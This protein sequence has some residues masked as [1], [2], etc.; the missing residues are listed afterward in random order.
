[1]W[2]SCPYNLL[3]TPSAPKRS[4]IINR[5][6]STYGN[7][8]GSDGSVD[9]LTGNSASAYSLHH[10]GIEYSGG[11]RAPPDNNINSYKSELEGVK[12][13]Q[14]AANE[15]E[16][17]KLTHT[18]D[19]QSAVDAI[20]HTFHTPAQMLSPEADIILAI[21]HQ[22]KHGPTQFNLRWI[23]AH[24]DDN[25]PNDQLDVDAKV[26]QSA[27]LL[28]KEERLH[29]IPFENRPYQ[30]SGAMLKIGNKWITSD[31]KTH[32]QEAI[33][34]PD[35]LRWFKTKYNGTDNRIYK[36]ET[37]Y[38]NIYW[39]GIGQARKHLNDYDNVR[40]MKLMNGW[41]NSGRQKGLFGKDTECP[42]CGCQEETQLHIF[43]CKNK[44][45]KQTRETAFKLLAK[46][47][48][49]HNIPGMVYVPFI[50]LCRSV[51]EDQSFTAP[52]P[53]HRT[54]EAAIKSQQTLGGE[55]LLRG[56]LTKEW[57][58]AIMHFDRNKPEQRLTHLYKGLW[59]IL[60]ASMWE[61]RNTSLHGP[62][63]LSDKYERERL[64]DELREWKRISNTRLGHRQQYLTDYP[65]D[66]IET[67]KT[68]TMRETIALLIKASQN[69][70]DNSLKPGQ[71][72][73]T[74]YFE[75]IDLGDEIS[76]TS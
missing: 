13:I 69:H 22:R 30:G 59:K 26:N 42:A 50:K 8:G 52:G 53:H 31:Y 28:A 54:V 58:Q 49:E 6:S 4:S 60:F 55:F 41:L 25:L 76:I 23:K 73:I 63:N 3:I 68:A 34:K 16:I 29:G 37:D 14:D 10:N 70:L 64:Q 36:S 51:C 15:I 43:Q 44:D 20:T 1:L 24:Q 7:R 33:M 40:I 62:N 47:Y 21:Q 72:K 66:E 2:T 35:H 48:H 65:P 9:I 67:W 45:M 39:K 19:N 18:C 32:I 27:D 61:Q 75:S 56:Y 5:N 71:R 11:H 46:Y 74:S 38:N 17:D 57:L 12:E